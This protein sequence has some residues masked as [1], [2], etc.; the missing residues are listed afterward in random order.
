MLGTR[1]GAFLCRGSDK[2]FHI[3]LSKGRTSSGIIGPPSICYPP[4]WF[5]KYFREYLHG[6]FQL[7]FDESLRLG[8]VFD[9]FLP[10]IDTNIS[11]FFF[12]PFFCIRV[13]LK[14]PFVS[15]VPWR[16]LSQRCFYNVSPRVAVE[17]LVVT[18]DYRSRGNKSEGGGERE[19]KEGRS[20]RKVCGERT[21]SRNAV[22][23][24]FARPVTYCVHTLGKAGSRVSVSRHRG[25]RRG[26]IYC[27]VEGEGRTERTV[28]R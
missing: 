6:V 11:I 24:V 23:K 3:F 19:R 21:S 27:T 12:S 25:N 4:S 5:T 20:R 18:I 16:K 14:P 2:G 26:W 28:E 10:K 9:F 8:R 13:F 22:F 17:F 1:G 7:R 15:C